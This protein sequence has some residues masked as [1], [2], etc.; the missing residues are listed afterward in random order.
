MRSRALLTETHML[1]RILVALDPDSDT[2]TATRCAIDIARRHDSEIVG[3]AVIDMGRIDRNARGGGIGSMYYAE[4]LREALTDETREQARI[5]IQSFEETV[6]VSGVRYRALTQEGVPFERIIEDMKYHDLLVA[7]RN[8][9]FFYGRPKHETDTLVR[10]VRETVGPT[11]VV[12]TAE[13]SIRRV[14]VAYDGSA[15]SARTMQHFVQTAPFG[16]DLELEILN[17]YEEDQQESDLIL[18][19]ACEYFEAHGFTPT[20]SSQKGSDAEHLIVEHA[21][22]I[23]ADLAVAGAHSA[24]GLRRLAF[25]STTERLLRDSKTPLYLAH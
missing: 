5:L 18:R 3:L 9:H 14:L 2:P 23:G 20:L 1:K 12:G 16:T 15:P 13:A 24:S 21:E 17:V 4:K 11:L 19:L 7:G 6:A 8:P 10:V 25:G 22:D